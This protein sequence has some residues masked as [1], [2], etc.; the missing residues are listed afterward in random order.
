MWRTPN[1]WGSLIYK[2]VRII[3]FFV[4]FSVPTLPPTL[5]LDSGVAR[6]PF[7]VEQIINEI[8][9]FL[10]RTL[11]RGSGGVTPEN[12]LKFYFAVGEF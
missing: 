8:H 2:W 1:E 6:L 12:F 5:S 7:R 4:V 11:K 10:P 3:S 9:F